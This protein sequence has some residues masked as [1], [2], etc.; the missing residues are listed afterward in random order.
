MVMDSPAIS[1]RELKGN[2]DLLPLQEDSLTDP[3]Y[4]RYIKEMT[5]RFPIGESTG[6][7][8]VDGAKNA[9]QENS[10]FRVTNDADGAVASYQYKAPN[11]EWTNIPS[12]ADLSSARIQEDGR[13]H[14]DKKDG[15][16]SVALSADGSE[17]TK[18]LGTTI[19]R[20]S[21]GAE[22]Y[23][24]VSSNGSLLEKHEDNKWWVKDKD[25]SGFT[26]TDG[27]IQLFD[28]GRVKYGGTGLAYKDY[29]LGG[30]EHTLD[31]PKEISG[32]E[33][34]PASTQVDKSLQD[35]AKQ[36]FRISHA[37]DGKINGC[38]IKQPN[39]EWRDIPADAN[40]NSVRVQDDG[41]LHYD[42]QD[43]S[44]KV[45]VSPDG[46]EVTDY[47]GT[48]IYREHA[49]AE[50]YKYESSNGSILEQHD[51]GKWWIKDKDDSDFTS[52]GGEIRMYQNGTITYGGTGLSF[53]NQYILGGSDQFTYS[54]R[55]NGKHYYTVR[56]DKLDDVPIIYSRKS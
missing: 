2:Q 32:S 44:G 38:Q 55:Y 20:K 56:A 36:S 5:T 15:K 27:D 19:Y 53:R 4:S 51:D 3:N 6:L 35:L 54:S 41:K 33:S 22:P 48:K 17:E 39:G 46:R 43:G 47:L 8:I 29:L 42:K 12:D 24:Y 49:G 26:S 37:D 25:D 31:D 11:G 50:P 1:V 13:L 9:I 52:A 7:Q 18:Y 28:D 30:G 40:L 34:S 45:T 23:K 16:S 14:Y 10:G 21:P